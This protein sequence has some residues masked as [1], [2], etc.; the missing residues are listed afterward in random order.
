MAD[1]LDVTAFAAMFRPL[2][3]AET[4]V[5]TPLLKVVDGWIRDRKPGI[6][7]DDPAAKVV[8]FQ[9]VRTALI[10]GKYAGLSSFQD[11]TGDRTKAGTFDASDVEGFIT[12]EHRQMLGLALRAGPRGSFK[13]C[14]Y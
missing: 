7:D 1:F 5:A 2:T 10:Y 4:N 12:D 13:T 6:A 11:T 8:V 14:D 3:T 9:V